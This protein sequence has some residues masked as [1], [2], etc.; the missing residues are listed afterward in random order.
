MPIR[1]RS[2]RFAEP[3]NR[4][5]LLVTG[6]QK[7]HKFV[8][9]S[10][11][12]WGGGALLCVAGAALMGAAAYPLFRD[13]MLAGLVD[14]QTRI[15]YAYEDRLA[16]LRLRLDQATSRQYIDQNGVEGKVQSLVLRQAQLETRAAVLAQLLEKT[17]T[18]D[19]AG[20]LPRGFGVEQPG[21]ATSGLSAIDKLAP[22]RGEKL[23][24]IAAE[25]GGVLSYAPKP[26]PE[27]V[28][29]RFG[30]EGDSDP[31]KLLRKG[32]DQTPLDTSMAPSTSLT[33]AADPNLPLSA[34]LERLALSLDRIEREQTTRLSDV[35]RPALATANRLR[36]AFEVAGL[37][38]ERYVARA[39]HGQIDLALGGPFVPAAP[40]ARTSAF[41]RELAAAQ[42][43]VSTLDG[44]RRA[45]SSAPLR[46]PFAGE[47][48]LTSPFGYRT[49]PFL[50][51]LALHSGVDLREGYGA[52]ARA[53]AAGV[54]TVAG[55]NGGYGN[56]VEVDHGGG[57]S[58]R[59]AHL[60][61]ISV[62]PGRQVAPGAIVGRVGSSG[63][64]TGPH[65]H[66]EVRI[67]GE[68]VDPQRFLR[69]AT[70]LGEVAQ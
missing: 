49:D 41:D 67:D 60:S 45:L 42:N 24:P 6:G 48:Q 25:E 55:P 40:E 34:R 32:F 65:L 38:V 26:Q 17:A 13:E 35:I 14:R 36:R 20:A 3:S 53:T 33:L 9:P 62:S 18:H 69:A 43:A 46:K 27:G 10:A 16:A 70:A 51:R 5:V 58:T 19:G 68:P 63:R 64:S 1:E 21:A 47:L 61:T 54:V 31:V 39:K 2:Y 23:H 66:Y 28:E 8:L 30:P 15:Q 37:R 56:M 59:Y 44:L 22:P 4:H 7:N 29:L 11:A 12:I 50:G 52:P 57:L